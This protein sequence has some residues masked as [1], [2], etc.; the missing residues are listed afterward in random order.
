MRRPGNGKHPTNKDGSPV[1]RQEPTTPPPGPAGTSRSPNLVVPFPVP[2]GAFEGAPMTAT[3]GRGA[4]DGPFADV[5]WSED[6]KP[7]H[8]FV[9]VP[10]PMIDRCAV[11]A[12]SRDNAAHPPR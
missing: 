12:L 5:G 9:P 11:C 4:E 8:E 6:D 7:T 3:S 2:V 1:T 10:G